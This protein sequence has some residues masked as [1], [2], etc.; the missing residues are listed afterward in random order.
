MVELD[1]AASHRLANCPRCDYSLLGL[2]D[3]GICPE[4]GQP[5]GTHEFYLYGNAMGT[6]RNIWNSYN[7]GPLNLI[8]SILG[9]IT[10]GAV[11]FFWQAGGSLGYY[12]NPALIIW[13]ALFAASCIATL[14]RGF[15]DQGSGVVQVRLSP[16][17]VRQ[18]T[19]GLGPQPYEANMDAS[20]IPW[21]QI[22]EAEL[23]WQDGQALIRLSTEKSFFRHRYTEYVHAIFSC[24]RDRFLDLKNYLRYWLSQNN[25]SSA[26]HF[27]EHRSRPIHRAA[28][29]LGL[30]LRGRPPQPPQ[31]AA[32]PCTQGEGRGEGSAS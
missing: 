3:S 24:D 15:T 25:C 29:R 16:L 4:C 6:R 27:L 18:G 19:R 13:S 22:K 7:P 32:S 28:R 26:L 21:T 1:Y 9:L 11:L 12:H 23:A 20:L 8:W 10:C 14:L 31:N 5:Y 30:R 17:G 2:P